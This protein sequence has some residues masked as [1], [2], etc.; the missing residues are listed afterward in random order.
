MLL[1]LQQTEPK[2]LLPFFQQTRLPQYVPLCH[3]CGIASFFVSAI[4]PESP[5]FDG[6]SQCHSD[7]AVPT[8]L[9]FQ[10]QTESS[11]VTP[12]VPVRD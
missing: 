9:E 6:Y 11:F 4:L 2:V 10:Q 1:I 5:T 8:G 3:E 12:D 7:V